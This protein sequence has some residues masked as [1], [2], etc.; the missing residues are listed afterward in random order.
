MP[1]NNSF[2]ESKERIQEKKNSIARNVGEKAIKIAGKR[3][4]K[5]VVTR[6]G[7][8]CFITVC[9]SYR[10]GI[11]GITNTIYSIWNNCIFPNNAWSN[12]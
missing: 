3:G 9:T 2:E 11:I 5:N 7:C 4:S 8:K 12:G 6:E 1:D 10:L